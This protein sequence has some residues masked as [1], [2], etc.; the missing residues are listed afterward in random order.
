MSGETCRSFSP[1]ILVAYLMHFETCLHDIVNGLALVVGRGIASIL[2][3]PLPT[4]LT[5][6][7]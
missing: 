5:W 6:P 2:S 7:G 1:A 4:C 3:G